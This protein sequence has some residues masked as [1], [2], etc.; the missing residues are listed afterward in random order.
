MDYSGSPQDFILTLFFEGGSYRVPIHLDA[1]A[2]LDLDVASLI[3]SGMPDDHGNVIPS[4]IQEGSALLSGA[5]GDE[6]TKL[7]VAS[8]TSTFNVRNGTCSNQCGTCD[9]VV[10][11]DLIPASISLGV[12]QSTQATGEIV[13]STGSAYYYTSDASSWSSSAPATASV[14]SSGIVT[15]QAVGSSTISFWIDGV[16]VVS[17]YICTGNSFY[18]PIGGVGGS[19]PE[20]S[21]PT[22]TSK[23]PLNVPLSNSPGAANG[24]DTI[25]LT[26]VGDPPGGTYSWSAD[27]SNVSISNQ[28]S[29]TVSVQAQRLEAVNAFAPR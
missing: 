27:N 17:G 6:R 26:A 22:V 25:Q 21:P 18:C 7:Y 15:S 19:G 20:S 11:E 28:S 14:A 10:E 8:T 2:D 3:R 24:T 29:S 4:N 1:R 13:Y 16:V 5:A 23:G 9:G 12:G